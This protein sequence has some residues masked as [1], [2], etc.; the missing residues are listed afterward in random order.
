MTEGGV[1]F[2]HSTPAFRTFCG[3]GALSSLAG[4]LDHA[5]VT[6]VVVICGRSLSRDPAIVGRVRAVLAGR[7]AGWFDEVEEHSPV[8]TVHSARDL[9]RHTAADSVVAIGGGSAIVTARAATILLA[10]ERDV[11]DLCTRRSADGRL[12]SPRLLAPK[13]PLWIVPST[14]TTAYAKAGSAVRDPESGQRM[15]MYDPKTRA[16]GVFFDP[17]IASTAPASVVIGSALNAF[18][19]AVEGLQ[20]GGADPLAEALLTHALTILAEWLPRAA[21]SHDEPDTRLQLMVGALLCGQGS[22]FVPGGLAQAISHA[23]GPRSTVSNGVVEALLLRHTIQYNAPAAERGTARIAAVLHGSPDGGATPTATA[24]AEIERVLAEV[25]V[26]E[27]LRDVGIHRAHH[28]K[29]IADVMDDW[30]V[31]GVPRHT[32]PDQLGQLLESAW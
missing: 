4:E 10:E 17:M 24:L 13:L 26:P 6:R 14:P 8:P 27:R 7:L 2:R 29:I 5:G 1:S 3:T 20:A 32:G 23:V 28:P 12:V 19:M 31:T 15:A 22:D 30:I 16:R 18:S 25:H 21:S 9:L 11:A